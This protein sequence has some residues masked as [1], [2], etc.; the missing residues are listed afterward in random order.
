MSVQTYEVP[1][2]SC[3]HCVRTIEREV[4]ELAGVKS[5]S[6]DEKSKTV[7]VEFDNESIVPQFKSLMEEIGYPVKN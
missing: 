3:E 1:N 2:I 6:A 5:I 7:T 4:K